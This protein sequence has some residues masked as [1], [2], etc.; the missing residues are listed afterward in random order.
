L[1]N[2]TDFIFNNSVPFSTNYSQ[3]VYVSYNGVAVKSP[4]VAVFIAMVGWYDDES[5]HNYT[6]PRPSNFTRMIWKSSTDVGFGVSS[7]GNR[8]VIVANYWPAP[9]ADLDPESPESIEL[10]KANVLPP[11]EDE[12]L[13]PSLQGKY[14]R[15]KFPAPGI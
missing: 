9:P 12:E 6:D 10:Y 3:N 1:V 2:A 14:V 5:R 7:F 4:P 15:V 13:P 8:T 11:L